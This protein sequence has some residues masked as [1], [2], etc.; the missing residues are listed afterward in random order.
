[1]SKR[2]GLGVWVCA[3]LLVA[4]LGL[5][6]WEST[7]PSTGDV[8]RAFSDCWVANRDALGSD[9]ALTAC[10]DEA[11]RIG[12]RAFVGKYREGPP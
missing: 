10:D 9:Q 1:M 8:Q 6:W 2:V 12:D 3:A 5:A 4:L 11:E 7:A